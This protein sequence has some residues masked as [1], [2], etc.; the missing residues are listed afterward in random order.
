MATIIK[1]R[2][3]LDILISDGQPQG[4]KW[5][6]DEDNRKKIPKDYKFPKE[7]KMNRANTLM[8]YHNLL[9]KN[10]LTILVS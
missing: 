7:Y 1:R 8:R 4:G 5:T 3:E 10:F 2:K 6:F 9:T